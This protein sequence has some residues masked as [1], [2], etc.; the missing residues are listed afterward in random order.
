MGGGSDGGR[1]I[2][3]QIP[4][5][6]VPAANC[7]APTSP[8][9]G[10]KYQLFKGVV[11]VAETN[12]NDPAYTWRSQGHMYALD[13]GVC[14]EKEL[15][16]GGFLG[17]QLQYI[18]NPY[19]PKSQSDTP[20]D[21]KTA[22]LQSTTTATPTVA[23]TT[24]PIPSLCLKTYTVKQGDSGWAIAQ[25]HDITLTSVLI[26]NPGVAW[27]KLQIGSVIKLPSVAKGSDLAGCA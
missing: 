1:D 27:D 11:A 6:F 7:R 14:Q 24:S 26:L 5:G 15:P 20:A 8:S 12:C 16:F 23:P 13:V 3:S 17:M 25:A 19:A 9:G 4:K 2:P 18:P 22:S 21:K 10:L